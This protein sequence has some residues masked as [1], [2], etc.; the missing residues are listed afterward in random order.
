MVCSRR[1]IFS[2][3]SANM[4]TKSVPTTMIEA[5]KSTRYNKRRVMMGAS[6]FRGG[7]RITAGSTGSTPRLWLGGPA[8]R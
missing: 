5:E 6:F 7:R 4:Y 8:S 1:D 3:S 2:S